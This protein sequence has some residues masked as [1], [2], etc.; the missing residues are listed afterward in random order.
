MLKTPSCDK[1]KQLFEHI[2]LAQY[3][4]IEKLD[5]T[6]RRIESIKSK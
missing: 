4:A 6:E 5:K 2:K 3:D 1:D